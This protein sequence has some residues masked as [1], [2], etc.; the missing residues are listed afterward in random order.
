MDTGQRENMYAQIN[1]KFLQHSLIC[2]FAST[3]NN[4]DTVKDLY[5]Y[6][7]ET[8]HVVTNNDGLRLDTAYG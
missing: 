2:A 8:L 4:M 1:G 7:Q 5:S 6:K 3:K